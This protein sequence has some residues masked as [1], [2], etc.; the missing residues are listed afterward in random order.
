MIGM[1][2][3]VAQDLGLHRSSDNWI[4]NNIHLFTEEQNAV[5][6]RIW[7]GCVKVDKC[8]SFDN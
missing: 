7:Y 8:V 5:R 6:K 3:S 1:A 2:I 4:R